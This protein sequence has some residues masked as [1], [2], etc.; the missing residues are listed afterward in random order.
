[1]CSAH[2][3]GGAFGWKAG[4]QRAGLVHLVV[5]GQ[6]AVVQVWC[7]GDETFA[8]EEIR[9]ALHLGIQTPPFLND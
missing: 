1:L 5:A 8:G 7:Q 9:H 2:V 6:F 3:F 4:H